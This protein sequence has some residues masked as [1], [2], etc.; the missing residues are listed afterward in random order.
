MFS[1]LHMVCC[2]FVITFNFLIFFTPQLESANSTLSLVCTKQMVLKSL[3]SSPWVK[4]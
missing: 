2:L 4:C 3:A 1:V